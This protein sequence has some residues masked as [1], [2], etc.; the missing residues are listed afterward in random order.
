M[1]V[2]RHSAARGII[3]LA[4]RHDWL[5]AF[6][7]ELGVVLAVERMLGLEVPVRATWVCTPAGSA[8][9]LH[10]PTG[11]AGTGLVQVDDSTLLDVA[12]AEWHDSVAGSGA[13]V[14]RMPGRLPAR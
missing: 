5:S 4:N 11:Q 7:T 9:P 8:S 10:Q 12:A 1:S 2:R 13:R 14:Q 6:S 3:V